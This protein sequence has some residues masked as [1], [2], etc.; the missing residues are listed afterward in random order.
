MEISLREVVDMKQSLESLLKLSL[1]A[2]VSF[3]LGKVFRQIQQEQRDFEGQRENLIRKYGSENK[4]KN[5]VRVLNEN[6]DSFMKE[7]NSLL[8]EKISI[9]YE[10]MSIS[11]LNNVSISVEDM[12]VL[13]LFFKD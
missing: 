11:D 6:I 4:D 9:N 1:P 10:P 12:S 13:S 8:E 7:V 3:R 5:E 2:K